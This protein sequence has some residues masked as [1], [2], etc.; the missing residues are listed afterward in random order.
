MPARPIERGL[1][2]G[3]S[4]DQVVSRTGSSYTQSHLIVRITHDG[5]SSAA[6]KVRGRSL[7]VDLLTPQK[8]GGTKPIPI[9]RF[10]AAAQSL[11]HLDYLIEESQPAAVGGGSD[12]S[13]R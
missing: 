10:G 9:P 5:T 13:I 11:P 1:Q 4:T 12:S 6:F 2:K 3:R 7:R 8:R